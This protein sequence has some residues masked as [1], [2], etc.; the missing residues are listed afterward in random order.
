MK[1]IFNREWL[2]NYKTIPKRDNAI[3]KN[4]QNPGMTNWDRQFGSL[5]PAQKG[6]YQGFLNTIPDEVKGLSAAEMQ[7]YLQGVDE[8]Q[9]AL[10]QERAGYEGQIQN[11]KNQEAQRLAQ[12]E[13]ERNMRRRVSIPMNGMNGSFVKRA[14]YADTNELLPFNLLL[15]KMQHGEINNS[16]EDYAGFYYGYG[17]SEDP[18]RPYHIYPDS[19]SLGGYNAA[20]IIGPG[21]SYTPRVGEIVPKNIMEQVAQ[22]RYGEKFTPSSWRKYYWNPPK[23]L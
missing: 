10:A 20:Y 8:K 15:K 13:E 18:R 22:E 12:A 14:L 16:L 23:N 19:K 17:K 21:N 4:Y 2:E 9:N 11:I 1:N 3:Y 5:S 6:R 7:K